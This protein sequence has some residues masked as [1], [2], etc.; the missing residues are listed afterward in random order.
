MFYI[1][2]IIPSSTQTALLPAW[3]VSQ[4]PTF[5]QCFSPQRQKLLD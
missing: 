2:L 1:I 4:L 5:R 3:T